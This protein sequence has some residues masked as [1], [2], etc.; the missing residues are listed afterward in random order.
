MFAP[1]AN[2]SKIVTGG[3]QNPQVNSVI[4][5]THIEVNEKG[6]V[7]AAVTGAVVIPLMGTTLDIL[8]LNHPFLFFIR[9]KTTGAILFGGR[10][11]EPTPYQNN[12]Q[13]VQGQASRSPRPTATLPPA[14][15]KPNF[16]NPGIEVQNP[17]P[18][19]GQ[20]IQSINS[21]LNQQGQPK[22]I[23][24][25]NEQQSNTPS[26][27]L[28]RGADGSHISNIGKPDPGHVNLIPL[29]SQSSAIH[30]YRVQPTL[31]IRRP[32]DSVA[33]FVSGSAQFSNQQVSKQSSD[34]SITFDNTNAQTY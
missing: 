28:N 10:V 2:L 12:R 5:K 11:N 23:Y 4:H 9:D 27:S 1:N 13:T 25:W 30:I 31:S 16:G 26:N 19:N 32:E 15:R 7:A 33:L 18:Y 20:N 34:D 8:N 3:F 21:G 24:S 17:P 6:A 22:N 14:S 29:S